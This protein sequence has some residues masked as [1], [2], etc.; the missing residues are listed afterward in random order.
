MRKTLKI[1]NKKTNNLIKKLAHDLSRHLTKEDT[2]IANKHMKRSSTLQV[3][4]E[5]QIKTRD[6]TTHL[7]ER[8]NPG[9]L[10][11]PSAVEGV[12]RQALSL[13]AGGN[14]ERTASW[15]TAWRFLTKLNTLYHTINHATWYLLKGVKTYV[16]TTTCT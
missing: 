7:L 10:M 8:P 13:V 2:L 6:T 11:P 3:V 12:G 9:A 15:T 5:M 14:A 1:Q 4:R 16:Y